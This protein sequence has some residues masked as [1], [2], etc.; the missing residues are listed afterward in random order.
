MKFKHDWMVCFWILAG[1]LDWIVDLE[2]GALVLRANG[3]SSRYFC[4][5]SLK[6]PD[7]FSNVGDNHVPTHLTS[8]GP[9][10]I[11]GLEAQR[12]NSSTNTSDSWYRAREMIRER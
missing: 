3:L 5:S 10:A 2:Y 9:R 1:W 11:F 7:P 6:C 8:V 12:D 4:T